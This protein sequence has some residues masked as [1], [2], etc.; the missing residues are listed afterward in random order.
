MKQFAVASS[1]KIEVIDITKQVQD[2]LAAN[3]QGLCLVYCP[4]TTAALMIGEN[5]QDLMKDYERVADTLFAGSRPFLH[6]GRGN[7]NAE[8]HIF[9]ALRG[10]S[11][12]VP[13]E[14]GQLQLGGFQSILL[15]ELDG[16]RERQ[17][18][19]YINSG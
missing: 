1:K 15:F 3:E 7:P 17:V 18:R 19:I 8:A 4:H 9:S 12:L 14:Q 5:E 6:C 13:V 10:C 11:V 16:P 2:Q